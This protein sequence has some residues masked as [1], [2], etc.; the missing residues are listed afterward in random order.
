P[1]GQSLDPIA[2]LRL[3]FDPAKSL[4]PILKTLPIHSPTAEVLLLERSG[5]DFL[6]L[7]APR[8]QESAALPLRLPAHDF[9]RPASKDFLGQ[10]GIVEGIDYRGTKV[11]GFIKAVPDSPWLVMAKFDRRE[12]TTAMISRYRIMLVIAGAF[13]LLCGVLLYLFW[14]K[15]LAAQDAAERAKWGQAIKN[16]DEFIQLMIDIMPNPAFFKDTRGLYQGTNSAFEKMGRSAASSASSR[17]SPR[18]CARRRRSNSS[19]SSATAPSR[20]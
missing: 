10:E 2:T 5:E 14:R 9:R 8:L 1:K 15:T 6:A 19:A 17:T 3:N 16:M 7:A 20:P 12:L 18:G 11:L 13:V 4:D